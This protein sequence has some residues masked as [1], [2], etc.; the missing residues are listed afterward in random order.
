MVCAVAV[1]SAMP[2]WDVSNI[3][4]MRFAFS[5]AT[6]FNSD[7]NGWDVSNVTGM[8]RMFDNAGL[9]T[10]NYDAILFGWS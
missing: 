4:D 8:E 6:A 3:T 10:D 5:D 7:L 9:S 1:S 2:D